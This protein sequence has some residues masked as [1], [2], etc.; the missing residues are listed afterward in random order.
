MNDADRDAIRALIQTHRQA[1]LA[2]TWEGSP[3]AAM[4]A[5]AEEPGLRGFLILLSG[6]SAHKRALLIDPAC[7][8]LICEPDDGSGDVM[9]R[10]RIALQGRAAVIARDATD[11][12]AARAIY[13]AKLPDAEMLFGLGDFDLLRI[14]PSSARFVAGF[15]RALTINQ[16][17]VSS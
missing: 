8:L 11:Y 16:W 7:S 17:Q 3:L 2:V 15:G 14:T 1:A 4:T 13:L 9:T 6:L 5:Y 10:Q 12:S